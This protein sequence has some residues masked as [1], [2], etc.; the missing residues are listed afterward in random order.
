LYLSKIILEDFQ[1]FE[2][3]EFA[4]SPNLNILV[5]ISNVGKSS[6]ARALSLIL[7]NKWDKS[8]CRFGTKYC[9]V[10]IQTDTGIEVMR[11][12]GEKINRYILRLPGQADQLFES[13]GVTTPEAVQQALKIHEVQIDS[14]DSL[15]LQLAGQMDSLFLLSQTGS[16]RAK[17]LGKLSGATYLDAAIREINKDKRQLTAEKQSKDLELVDLQAQIDKLAAIEGFSSQI[18]DI[19]ARLSSLSTQEARLQRIQRLFERVTQ[20]KSAW[21]SETEKEALLSQIDLS[22]IGQLSQRVDKIKKLNLLYDRIVNLDLS[23]EK[24]NKL[25]KLLIPI[26]ISVIPV[27]AEKASNLKQVKDLSARINKNQRELLGKT[28]ELKQVEQKYNEAKEQ[29]SEML[30]LNKVCPVCNQETINL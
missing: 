14:T 5:G 29:Y 6:V 22:S 2:K 1:A 16:Y 7:F 13:F 10:T 9:K 12:K 26:D 27:L 23:F 19:E 15:N 21:I 25:Q 28:D 8:W 18:S 20:L 4:L 24:Q 3:G 11:E 30:R 17:V